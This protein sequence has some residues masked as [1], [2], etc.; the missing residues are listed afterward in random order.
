MLPTRLCA[1]HL[2]DKRRL[3]GATIVC[4]GE[5]DVARGH[6]HESM[7]L[8]WQGV[9]IGQLLGSSLDIPLYVDNINVSI[10]EATQMN[11]HEHLVADSMLLRVANGLIGGAIMQD[12]RMLRSPNTR[13]SWIGHHPI[14][15]GRR[16]CFCGEIGCLNT[17]ASAPAM[18]SALAG[19]KSSARFSSTDFAET[20]APVRRLI[21]SA[22]QGDPH[23]IRVLRAGGRQLGRFLVAHAG[24]FG[25]S[26]IH[27]AGFVGRSRHYFEGAQQGFEAKAPNSLKAITQLV[28]ND[29]SDE[30]AAVNVSLDRFLYSPQ[31]NIDR[32][33]R[34][35]TSKTARSSIHECRLTQ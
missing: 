11:D 34:A 1:S 30:Q 7:V 13:P 29:T 10:L 26:L 2:S 23:A 32:L 21:M 16:R 35:K 18:L 22:D 27:I 24:S 12:G 6:L 15:G 25:P 8:G 19:G 17:E 9:A 14:R 20:E 4:A 31:L 28:A 3:L 5:I 33:L